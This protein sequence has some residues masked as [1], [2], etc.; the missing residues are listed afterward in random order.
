[1]G[2]ACSRCGG[3][4]RCIQ[5]FSGE[6]YFKEDISKHRHRWANSTIMGLQEVGWGHGLKTGTRGGPL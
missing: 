2:G 6:T 4:A 1:M 5:G 3:E